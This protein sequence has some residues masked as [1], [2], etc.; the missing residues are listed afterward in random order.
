M[1]RQRRQ[2]L[3]LH[4]AGRFCGANG[5]V[6]GFHRLFIVVCMTKI[7][8]EVPITPAQHAWLKEVEDERGTSPRDVV[9]DLI[10]EARGRGVRDMGHAAA[11][12]LEA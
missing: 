11:R 6:A 4:G 5:C 1:L 7:R 3:D 2:G 8:F 10:A 9:R 12:C